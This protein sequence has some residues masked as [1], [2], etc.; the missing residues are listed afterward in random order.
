MTLDDLKTPPYKGV[1]DFEKVYIRLRQP[2]GTQARDLRRA[3][4]LRAPRP[5]SERHHPRQSARPDDH[6]LPRRSGVPMIANSA[7]L[8]AMVLLLLA[9]LVAGRAELPGALQAPHP[10]AVPLGDR[11]RARRRL[12]ESVRAVLPRRP[13]ACSSRRPA[14]SWP[15]SRSSCEPATRS[16]ATCPSGWRRRTDVSRDGRERRPR[17]RPRPRRADRR[18]GAATAARPRVPMRSAR[19]CGPDRERA[20]GRPSRSTTYHLRESEVRIARDGRRVPRGPRRRSAGRCARRA[21]R[22]PATFAHLREQGLIERKTVTV[23]REPT[24]VVVLTRDGKALLEAHQDRPSER[25]RAG[26]PRRPRQAARARPR[27]AAAIACFRPRPR[28]IEADGG[29][30]DAGRPRLRAEARLPDV[31]ESAAIGLDDAPTR[32][33]SRRSPRRTSLPDR[34]RPSRAAGPPHRVRDR[35][36]PRRTPRCGAR[37][38]ALFAQRSS[39][40][41]PRPASRS[42][43]RPARPRAAAARATGG[44]PF[45]PHHLEWLG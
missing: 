32:T 35:R 12:P 21:T 15:M 14:A 40:G 31:P 36:R 42:T 3:D 43:A 8:A 17:R 25:P 24:A 39:P 11:G 29:R 5:D 1:V 2:P 7:F 9:F 6:L 13:A 19:R 30:I 18:V 20:A 26:V 37:D 44:T 16:S 22:G 38:R 41:R 4:H 45:D 27:R 34:R 33:T 28:R 10:S 23:N